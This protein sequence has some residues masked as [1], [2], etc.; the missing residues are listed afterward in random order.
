MY[1]LASDLV[2]GVLLQFFGTLALCFIC[3]CLYPITFFPDSVQ[4]IAAFLP[5][6]LARMQLADCILL[7]HTLQTTLAL[8]GYGCLFALCAALVRKYKVAGVRG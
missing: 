6:G 4:K 1:E 7:K 5:V 3:G 8:L 2:S